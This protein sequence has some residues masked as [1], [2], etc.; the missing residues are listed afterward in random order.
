[1]KKLFTAVVAA[2][3]LAACTVPTT[4]GEGVQTTA[5]TV[6]LSSTKALV[7]ATDAYTGVAT[8]VTA[9]VN[10]GAFSDDQLRMISTL[11]NQ[12]L[13]LI[14]GTDTTLTA[15][16]RAASIG[17]VVTQLHSILGK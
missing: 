9:A 15:A 14:K 7:I 10:H 1:M 5:D 8:L 2:L 4:V 16:Q 6:I 11:N 13:A 3:S 17:L 12:A